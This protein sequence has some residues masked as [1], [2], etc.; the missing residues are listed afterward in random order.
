M[1]PDVQLYIDNVWGPGS[2]KPIPVLNPA[3]EEVIGTVACAGPGDLDRAL[4]RF[5]RLCRLEQGL[6]LRAIK[7]DAPGRRPAAEPD[8]GYC[9]A[10]D[11]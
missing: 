8:R 6:G 2:G 10:L 9:P 3:T 1:Y 4:A 7:A 5:S 11:S